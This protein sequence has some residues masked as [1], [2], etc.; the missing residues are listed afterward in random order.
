MDTILSAVA[1][2]GGAEAGTVISNPPKPNCAPVHGLQ[3]YEGFKCAVQNC[4]EVTGTSLMMEKHY[5]SSHQKHERPARGQTRLISC[6]IQSFF[7]RPNL[8]WFS[9][10]MDLADVVENDVYAKLIQDVIPNLPEEPHITHNS[11]RDRTMLA[12]A[13]DW[14]RYLQDHTTTK[15]AREDLLDL[16]KLPTE[17]EPKLFSVITIFRHYMSTI[18]NI[19][20]TVPV[21]ARRLLKRCPV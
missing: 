3:I 9:V 16:I 10:N 4:H 1:E 13:T 5:S 19:A 12:Q 7:W 6:A 18:G 21:L 11:N 15:K 8:K 2:L 20:G 14:D 17:R